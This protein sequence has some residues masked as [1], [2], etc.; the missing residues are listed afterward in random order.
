MNFDISIYPWNDYHNQDNEHT[1]SPEVPCVLIL[2]CSPGCCYFLSSTSAASLLLSRPFTTQTVSV[3]SQFFVTSISSICL[4]SSLF[5]I[6]SF[7]QVFILYGSYC[8]TLQVINNLHSDNVSSKQIGPFF[9][10]K[11]LPHCLWVE[12]MAF[13]AFIVLWSFI[14]FSLF[15]AP[16]M[17][18]PIWLCVFG[19]VLSLPEMSFLLFSASWTCYY[20]SGT[21]TGYCVCNAFGNWALPALSD[22][23]MS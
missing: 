15:L 19:W 4:L 21:H 16:K 11:M 2:L 22:Y 23:S 8:D 10:F 12:Y 7:V 13:W 18:V 9:I 20:S 14:D 1:S 6:V 5:I 17:P 3:T